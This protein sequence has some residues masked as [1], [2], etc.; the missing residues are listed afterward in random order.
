ML[1]HTTLLS[2]SVLSIGEAAFD[3]VRDL[4]VM[5]YEHM[6]G[7]SRLA[8][9]NALVHITADAEVHGGASPLYHP[10][11]VAITVIQGLGEGEEVVCDCVCI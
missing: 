11:C 10:F 3:A 5:D 8:L 6:P 1:V 7:P 4:E 9:L 2:H